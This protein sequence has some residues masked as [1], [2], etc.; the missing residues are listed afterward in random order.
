[1]Q[2]TLLGVA[3]AIILALVAALVGP[4]FIDWSQFRAEFEARGASVTGLELRIAG[5]IDARLLPTPTLTLQ[6]I[7]FGRPGDGS[8]IR[9]RALHIEYALGALV[10]G[11]WRVD[12]ARLDGPEFEIGLDGSGRVLWPLPSNGF[13]PQ[14]ASIQR[15]NIKDGRATLA[16]DA[17][18]SRLAGC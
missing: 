12:E 18:G 13:A 10:R 7:E 14:E 3:I 1:V 17:S 6:D 8:T 4:L 11:E 5:R 2:T 9:V 15:L 16:N